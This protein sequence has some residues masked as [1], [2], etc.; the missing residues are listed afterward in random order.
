MRRLLILSVLLASPALADNGDVYESIAG[1]SIGRVFLTPEERRLL[2]A[3]R[4]RSPQTAFQSAPSSDRT[5]DS[6]PPS[7]ASGYIVSSS[8]KSRLWRDG[9]FVEA[10]IAPTSAT[11]FPGD[12]KIVRH[13]ADSGQSESSDESQADE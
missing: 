13:R 2:D 10:A 7:N 12:V 9:D 8:G 3:L 11:R 1:I 6:E 4:A 5:R